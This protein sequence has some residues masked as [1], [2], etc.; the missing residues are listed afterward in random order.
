[1]WQGITYTIYK[2]YEPKDTFMKIVKASKV[3]QIGIF[4][5]TFPWLNLNIIY[6][7]IY[8]SCISNGLR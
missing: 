4:E 1:M 8:V 3:K 7:L 2:L 6:C 5:S